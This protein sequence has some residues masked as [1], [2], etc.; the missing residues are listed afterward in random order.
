MMTFVDNHPL[1]HRPAGRLVWILEVECDGFSTPTLNSQME[2][3]VLQNVP[4][5]HGGAFLSYAANKFNNK[6][7]SHASAVPPHLSHPST[8]LKDGDRRGR[9]P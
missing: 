5:A 2:T 4:A 1:S 9:F 8:Q 6:C 3:D 7:V